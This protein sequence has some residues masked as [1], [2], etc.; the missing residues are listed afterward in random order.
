MWVHLQASICTEWAQSSM[1]LS[2][3]TQIGARVTTTAQQTGE[4]GAILQVRRKFFISSDARQSIFGSDMK[5]SRKKA[6]R[7]EKH[8]FLEYNLFDVG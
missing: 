4:V 6:G 3:G 8:V 1:V 2:P 5:S 7:N